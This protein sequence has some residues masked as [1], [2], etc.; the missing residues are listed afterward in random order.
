MHTTRR[1]AFVAFIALGAAVVL[2]A[3]SS[4][5]VTA[6]QA[7]ASVAQGIAAIQLA[8]SET[9][10]VAFALDAEGSRGWDID[11]AANGEVF[12]VRVNPEGT[13]VT[14]T[15]SDGRI[16]V[17]DRLRL[18]AA[19]VTLSDAITT[20]ADE[21][22]GNLT[23]AELDRFMATPVVWS[24]TFEN[25]SDDVEVAVDVVTGKVVNVERD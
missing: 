25:G 13:S 20:A 24:V 23:E 10:G 3:C 14:S 11:V 17:D 21:A 6:D 5:A 9:D 15:R 1:A 8:E 7:K 16:D 12:E 22:V 18:E 2:S 4:D 19:K